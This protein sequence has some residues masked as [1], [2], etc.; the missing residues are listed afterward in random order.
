MTPLDTRPSSSGIR[1]TGRRVFLRFPVLEDEQEFLALM[2]RSA[3]LH[4]GWVTPPRTPRQFQYHVEASSRDDTHSYWI[5]LKEGGAIAGFAT[6]S[7]IF[8]GG[9]QSAYLGYAA[10][11]P[12]AGQG[13]MREGL[14]LLLK[15]IFQVLKLHRVE[16]NIQPENAASLALIERVGFRPE[17]Y[18]PRYLKICRRWC[19]HERWALLAEEWRARQKSEGRGPRAELLLKSYVRLHNLG[20]RTGDF[21]S[22]MTLFAPGAAMVFHG[23]S[24]GPLA[25]REEIRAAFRERAPQDELVLLDLRTPNSVQAEGVYAWRNSP[26][27]RAGR[28]SVRV[29]AGRI[30]E[31]SVHA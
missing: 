23:L 2:R 22:M 29:G 27:A 1:Q 7:Q 28:L 24:F 8:R 13:L 11:G 30:T 9:F 16:A 26:K 4:R 18:S 20:V 3:R 15:E 31:L 19:D 25:G 12:Y 5:C 21:R 10:G 14:E 17:G 6:L